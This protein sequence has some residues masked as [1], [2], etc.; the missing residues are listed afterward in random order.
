MSEV[1][2]NPWKTCRIW[3]IQLP[4]MIAL[5]DRLAEVSFGSSETYL[6]GSSGRLG[7]PLSPEAKPEVAPI[8]Q[9]PVAL[10]TKGTSL[11]AEWEVA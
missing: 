3:A 1:A 11:E 2:D 6:A 4:Q 8:P 10:G 7:N 5:S 9:S